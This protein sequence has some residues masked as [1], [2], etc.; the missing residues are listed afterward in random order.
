M[1]I[2][3]PSNLQCVF[4]VRV[5]VG[6]ECCPQQVGEIPGAPV[7]APPAAALHKGQALGW[8]KQ[9]MVRAGTSQLPL[10]QGND[11]PWGGGKLLDQGPAVSCHWGA[12]FGKL[13]M[14]MGFC[15]WDYYFFSFLLQDF[16][17]SMDFPALLL[18]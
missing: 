17:P 5:A 4:W 10:E 9:H 7:G 3:F 12:G 16:F 1:P 6:V 2:T 14:T 13:L 18:C 15:T 8:G 11:V